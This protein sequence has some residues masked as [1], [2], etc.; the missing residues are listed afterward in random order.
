MRKRLC[1]LPVR[2]AVGRG[3]G[4]RQV[5][6]TT[7]MLRALFAA[8]ALA[9]PIAAHPAAAAEPILPLA[10]VQAGMRC[11]GHTVVRGAD[12]TAFDVEIVD[13]VPGDRVDEQPLLLVR[14]SGP[15]VEETGIA[16]GFSGAP[17]VCDGRIAGAIAYGTGD[18]GNQLGFATPIEAML[19]MPAVLPGKVR[20]A[21]ELRRRARPLRAPLSV[22]GLSPAVADLFTRAAAKAGLTLTAV[23]AAPVGERFPAQDPRPGASLAVGLSSG[24]VAVGAVGTTTYVDGTSV[25][26][27]G[28][29][30]DGVG[31]R[32]LLLQDAWVYAVVDNPLGVD[33][34]ISHKIAA[35]G[36]VLGT[37]TNDTRAGVAGV[38]GEVA[39][40]I[41]LRIT[42]RD[43][44]TGLR[45]SVTAQV[46]DETAVGLPSGVSPVTLVAPMAL[47]QA[48]H[49]ALDGSPAHQSAR[50]CVRIGL[51][52][53]ARPARFCNRYV[54]AYGAD[55]EGGAGGPFVTDLADALLALDD[56]GFGTPH[57]TSVDVA[58]DVERGMRLALLRSVRGPDV[59][60][61][62]TTAKLRLEL[63][64]YR[65]SRFTRTVGLRVP[66]DAR[67]GPQ[68]V[69]VQGTAPDGGFED[70]LVVELVDSL[71]GK[72]DGRDAAPKSFAQ[73]ARR[74]AGIHRFDGVRVQV[75]RKARPRALLTD[76]ELR[77]GGQASYRA[78]VR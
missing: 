75:G 30:L 34:A 28:H 3:H 37:I 62:G 41:P 12:I 77:I 33:G 73:L 67:R 60:R 32:S 20:G 76:P 53:L 47:A 52:E 39:P 5:A 29:Q 15:V 64:H 11:T 61:R 71:D 49:A 55:A 6:C 26:G 1:L 16:E 38:L 45:R 21:P 50:M 54:G 24:D 74:I 22:S 42:T 2:A 69:A 51:R 46:A 44:D 66:R 68:R 40:Q 8:V 48:A 9:L 65:G 59:L 14:V 43:V 56:F 4:R 23:P 25:W 78:R 27:F 13:V 18:Y 63:Q 72:A 31:R 19:G 10:E 70:E 57:V 36:H 58:L 35:P 17:V 7:D